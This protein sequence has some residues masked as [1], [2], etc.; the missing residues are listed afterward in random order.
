MTLSPSRPLPSRREFLA[1]TAGTLLA[2][3]HLLRGNGLF[4]DQPEGS[5]T[6]RTLQQVS[7]LLRQKRVSA[8]E[9]TQT[10]LSRIQQYQEI[11]NAFIT[12]TPE[13][14][15]AQARTMD[16]E[17][18]KGK[19][20]GPLHGVPLALKD[21]IDTAGILTTAASALFADRIPAEDAEVV[22]KLKSAGAVILGK[23]NMDE[24]AAGGTST[25][26]YYG[27]VHNPWQLDRTAG[28]SSGGS[29]AAVAAELCF[30]ALGTDTGGSI[31]GP[32]SFCGIV[33]LKPTY[34]R[35]SIRGI[36]PLSWTLDHV[37]PMCR[38][39]EDA[40]IVLQAL[41][42]YDPQD[43]TCADVPV[44]DYLAGM[45][46]PVASVRLGVPRVQFYDKLDAEVAAALQAALG[47]L[48]PLTA[49]VTD[50]ALPAVVSVPT[51]V[52][53]ETYAYHAPWFTR[54]PNLYQAPLRRRLEQVAKTSA[55]D[56]AL[57]RR[58]IDRLRREIGRVF[59]EV[60]LLITPTVKQPPR[61]LAESIK[62][63]EA[64]K[65]LPPE[66]GNTGAF[67]LFGLPTV[68]VPC[69]FTKAGLPVGLQISGPHFAEARVLALAHAYEQATEWHK[70]R[71]AL[72]AGGEGK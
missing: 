3:A 41:A 62:R 70:R 29:A 42:G 23:L 65:P 54:S 7:D 53:A 26:T 51:L 44:P 16:A 9:L 32:A 52:G 60:D 47:V 8:V 67:N 56:Y 10:C 49:S 22:R 66:L 12:V 71:P 6:G 38:T 13:K 4:P 1:A 72:K 69:G 58:E 19:W 35:V 24:F 15:L 64:E 25:A 33:G 63:A 61:T 28:G 2:S 50:V 68:S 46:M 39:V 18:Q 57:G 31:R 45:K 55:A 27:P 30:A 20:R 11:L 5:L 36:I 34:G 48:R 14:A 21:N 59:Q 37:G 40:A 17:L 43:T